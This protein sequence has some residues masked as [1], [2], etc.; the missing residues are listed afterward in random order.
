M[1]FNGFFAGEPTAAAV[2]AS[3][4][5]E[6]FALARQAVAAARRTASACR[7]SILSPELQLA[8]PLLFA[9]SRA[10]KVFGV[11]YDF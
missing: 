5:N 10:I 4:D 1:P 8:A 9:P 6:T 3:L 7:T 11:M 2:T